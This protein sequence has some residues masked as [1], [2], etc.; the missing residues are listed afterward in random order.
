MRFSSK[1]SRKAHKPGTVS[2]G[3]GRTHHVPKPQNARA[4]RLH[5]NKIVRDQKRLALLA[6]KRAGSESNCPPLVLVLIALSSRTNIKKTKNLII[7]KMTDSME[8]DDIFIED[9]T[10]SNVSTCVSPR[11]KLRLMVV[12]AP[13]E[14]LQGCLS[15]AKV[16]DIIA[17]VTT[18][19]ITEKDQY[20]DKSGK[21]CL[22]MLRAQGLPTVM[23]LMLDLMEIPI[24][25]RADAKKACASA[26]DAELPEGSKIFPADTPEECDQVLRQMCNYRVSN[27][28][29]RNQRPFVVAQQLDFVTDKQ[30]PEWGTLLLAGY[31]RGR[32]LSVNQLVHLTGLGDFQLKQ[33]DILEDPFPM[34]QDQKA[35]KADDMQIEHSVGKEPSLCPDPTLQEPLVVENT[36][37]TL[38]GEQTWP[39]KEELAKA[40]EENRQRGKKRLLPKGTS[41][42]QAAW[43]VDDSDNEVSDGDTEDEPMGAV[44]MNQEIDGEDGVISEERNHDRDSYLLEGASVMGDDDFHSEMMDEEE[45]TAEERQSQL[46]QL[47]AAYAAD[48]EFPD[49]VDT[50]LDM[51]ARQRFAKYRGLKSF[52]TSAWDPKES[53]PPEYGRIFSFDNFQRTQ[54]HILAKAKDVDEGKVTGCVSVG[55]YVRLHLK[56]VPSSLA[57]GL[58]G[59]FAYIPSVACGLLQ[60]ES[61]MSVLHFSIKKHESFTEPVKSKESLIFHSGFRV[62]KTRPIFSTDDI[63]MDKHKF[64]R[65]LHPGRFSVASVFTS[66]SF[67]P[68]PL[69]VFKDSPSGEKPILVASGSL[70]SVDP[71]RIIL[72]KIVLSGY[73]QRVQKQ[74]AVVRFMFHNPE[75]VHW[76]QRL[77]LWTKY[78][79]RGRIKEA[80]GTHGAMK[81]IFDGVLQQRDAVCVSLYKR[82]YPKWPILMS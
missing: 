63:N 62:Y 65:F 42:Y 40:K 38:A 35:L 10:E 58:R 45:L 16:A 31:V 78:G 27:P 24:K 55:T 64:E 13:Q 53:L 67:P 57:S 56:D 70:K 28:H 54:K 2:N 46:Q 7:K 59:T 82:V 61:K 29:W 22:S 50:P 51:L 17:F 76:F 69:V 43:I 79:R 41:E 32:G 11:H 73:P 5:R 4:V 14:D 25:R 39:T 18:A 33:V 21:L 20:V 19:A 15:I 71:D 37:D 66:I 80:V 30:L 81:C 52:R 8:T 44:E 26:L 36:P 23:G 6:E 1:S 68:L 12:E 60:H 47:K 34:R 72:K 3:A 9:G 77:E 75:D 74:R 49:E 48:E